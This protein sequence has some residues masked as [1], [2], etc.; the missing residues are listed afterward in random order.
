MNYDDVLK[1]ESKKLAE[2]ILDDQVQRLK[3]FNSRSMNESLRSFELL[4][5]SSRDSASSEPSEKQLIEQMKVLR[6]EIN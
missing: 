2:Q 4:S 5:S 3:S 1:L 6:Q